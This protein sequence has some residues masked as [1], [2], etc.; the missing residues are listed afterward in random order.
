MHMLPRELIVL[1]NRKTYARNLHKPGTDY[2]MTEREGG[3]EGK[4][5]AAVVLPS[6]SGLAGNPLNTRRQLA[7]SVGLSYSVLQE[8]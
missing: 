1:G 7:H 2:I 4:G 8:N 5:E 3:R 6:G